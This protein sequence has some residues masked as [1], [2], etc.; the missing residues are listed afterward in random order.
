MPIR[1]VFFD[2]G[3]T[4]VERSSDR[5][6]ASQDPWRPIALA[7]IQQEFGPQRWAER[8]YDADIRLPVE[9]DPYR[10]DTNQW[11]ARWLVANGVSMTGEQIERLRNCFAVPLD[12]V[13]PL[14]PGAAE[15]LRWCKTRQLTTVLVTNTLSRGDDEER[16]D[17]ERFGLSDAVDHIVTSHSTGW[18]KPHPAMFRR[19]LALASVAPA[20]A[21]MIGDQLHAD[22]VGAKQLG[23]A[24]VWKRNGSVADIHHPVRPDAIIESLVEV[25]TLLANWMNNARSELRQD[26]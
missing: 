23:I 26:S 1:A 16:R 25:P 22:I 17:W 7:S 20:E 14:A 12:L 24:T 9:D 5:P 13:V 18:Q 4:L 19:A 15:A 10:Q 21:V 3:D 2:V 8:L 6:P 11:L